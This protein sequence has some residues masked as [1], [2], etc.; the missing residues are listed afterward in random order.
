MKINE[1]W[2]LLFTFCFLF[3]PPIIPNINF[4]FVL[5]IYS[6]IVIITKYIGRLK[7]LLKSKKLKKIIL[8]LI[9]Y[10]IIYLASF[11]LN[12]IINNQDY[13][14]NYII[15]CY[16]FVLNYIITFICAIYITFKCEDLNYTK[17]EVIL[18]FIKAGLIQ[19]LFVVLALIN[20]AFKEWTI[21]KMFKETNRKLLESQWVVNRRFYGFSNNL[22]DLFGFGTGI[23]SSLPLFYGKVTG[24]KA[25]FLLSPI[26]LIAPFLNSRTGLIIF[27]VGLITLVGLSIFSKRVNI[28]EVIKYIVII[29]I[30]FII[31]Y[32]L[33]NYYSPK[34]LEWIKKDLLSFISDSEEIGTADFIFS[35]RFWNLPPLSKI[36]I[37]DGHSISGYSSGA[38]NLIGNNENNIKYLK[39]DNGYI[40]ELWKVGLVGTFILIYLI[41]F[42]TK[43]LNRTEDEKTYRTMHFYFELATLIFLVKGTIIGYNP[44]NVI[45]YTLLIMS[46]YKMEGKTNGK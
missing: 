23:I 21:K 7:V 34:T 17:N 11:S 27:S 28:V 38:A 33:I 13:L 14:S 30:V 39:S 8:L 31:I 10:N 42:T 26:L 24:K 32:N 19:V 9:V 12:S 1:I 22:L 3:A 4:S 29:L 16:S 37:G 36:M 15:N 44:G 18:L 35:S 46:I 40:N 2:L 20:P 43:C 25:Y 41:H 45:I 6:L 5:A